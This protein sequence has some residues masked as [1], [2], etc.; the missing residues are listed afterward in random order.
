MEKVIGGF[1]DKMTQG[2]GPWIGNFKRNQEEKKH[3]T[4]LQIDGEF[5]RMTHPKL[6]K[7]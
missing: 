6:L 2:E 1:A 5:I 7:I 4:Y 3:R